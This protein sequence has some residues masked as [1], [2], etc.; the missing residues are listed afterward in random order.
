MELEATWFFACFEKSCV[1]SFFGEWQGQ[2]HMGS[3]VK[4]Q[5]TK[6]NIAGRR[7]NNH[8][9]FPS[10]KQFLSDLGSSTM[11]IMQESHFR[12]EGIVVLKIGEF[13]IQCQIWPV[14]EWKM[15]TAWVILSNFWVSK[16]NCTMCGGVHAMMF[17]L[18]NMLDY[19]EL[20]VVTE[21]TREVKVG[22]GKKCSMGRRG[23][24]KEEWE[25]G[26]MGSWLYVLQTNVGFVAN[27]WDDANAGEEA[28]N[29]SIEY[30]AH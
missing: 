16:M 11:L 29:R 17:F 19:Y 24:C 28:V 7:G 15:K 18:P 22:K 10:I 8:I 2:I 21:G 5:N 26:K 12:V 14:T 1:L 6:R 23:C 4:K 27:W 25:R 13:R 20:K 30:L 9:E 3:C